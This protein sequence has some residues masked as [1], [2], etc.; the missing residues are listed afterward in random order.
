M[1]NSEYRKVENGNGNGYKKVEYTATKPT[2]TK[3]YVKN[4]AY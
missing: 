2:E 4:K 3:I 1:N